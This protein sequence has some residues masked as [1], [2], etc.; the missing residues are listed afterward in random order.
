M[1]SPLRDFLISTGIDPQRI[2][3]RG[4]GEE[5]PVASPNPFFFFF[6]FFFLLLWRVILNPEVR[7]ER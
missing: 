4:Y 7:V 5:H 1:A 6:F 2:N 3:A